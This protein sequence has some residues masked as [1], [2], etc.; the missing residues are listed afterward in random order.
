[1]PRFLEF[2][3]DFSLRPLPSLQRTLC[4]EFV[5]LIEPDAV[6]CKNGGNDFPSA[7]RNEVAV[8]ARNLLNEAVAAKH[9]QQT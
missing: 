1:M 2:Y 6:C 3:Q 5:E 9:S 4:S 8:R 7:R